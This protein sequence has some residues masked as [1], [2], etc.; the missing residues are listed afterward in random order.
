MREMHILVEVCRCHRI[1]YQVLEGVGPGR[2]V[3]CRLVLAEQ[4]LQFFEFPIQPAAG[5]NGLHVIDK[6]PH[7]P[8]VLQLFLRADCL[9]CIRTGTGHRRSPRPGNIPPRARHLFPAGIRGSRGSRPAQSHPPR[10]Y[11]RS[12]GRS[13]GTGAAAGSPGHGG[14]CRPARRTGRQSTRAWAGHE[15]SHSRMQSPVMRRF[16]LYTIPSPGGM[17]QVAFTRLLNVCGKRG[18]PCAVCGRVH[19]NERPALCHDIVNSSPPEFGDC[20]VLHDPG[21]ERLSRFRRLDR[22]AR[23]FH[24]E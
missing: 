17:P 22:I 3:F 12:S 14:S 1:N 5:K 16:P 11:P 19:L 2:V 23:F 10:R 15:R 7:I 20:L 8:G 18:K 6:S 4:V 13:Q 9:H 24:V 21:D